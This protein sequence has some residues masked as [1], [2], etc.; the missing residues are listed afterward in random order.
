MPS[1]N[2]A[3]E[4]ARHGGLVRGYE[5]PIQQPAVVTSEDMQNLGALSLWTHRYVNYIYANGGHN[6]KELPKRISESVWWRW[7]DYSTAL[8]DIFSAH[9]NARHGLVFPGF[10]TEEMNEYE[11][12][13]RDSIQFDIDAEFKTDA[14]QYRSDS[15]RLSLT[16]DADGTI[17]QGRYYWAGAD[18]SV[19]PAPDAEFYSLEMAHD[20]TISRRAA[21]LLGR[22]RDLV[23]GTEDDN[24]R[25]MEGVWSRTLGVRPPEELHAIPVFPAA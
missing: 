12:Q 17:V 7:G 3:K 22:Y 19:R 24:H 25:V 21:Q 14:D 8:R 1:R 20:A 2:K 10:K 23:L 9:S 4:I 16:L 5:R 6:G 13:S 11:R 15:D 18:P